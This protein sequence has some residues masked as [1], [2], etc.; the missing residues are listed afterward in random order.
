MG[1]YRALAHLLPSKVSSPNFPTFGL[2]AA[3]FGNAWTWES[4]Q[5]SPSFTW[6]I[7]WAYERV[8]WSG[9][10]LDAPPV[11]VPPFESREGEPRCEHGPFQPIANFVQPAPPPEIHELSLYVGFSP[12]VGRAWWIEGKRVWEACH[13]PDDQG[14]N[15]ACGWTDVGK[16]TSLGDQLWPHPVIAWA[17]PAGEAPLAER[18]D[19][20]LPTAHPKLLMDD[21]WNGGSCVQLDICGPGTGADDAIFRCLWVPVQTIRAQPNK[22]CEA[23]FVWKRVA[24]LGDEDVSVELDVALG[25]QCGQSRVPSIPVDDKGLAN[26]WSK[27]V[28][29]F[30]LLGSSI[31][32]EAASVGLNIGFATSDPSQPYKFSILLGQ[33]AV[34]PTPSP[35][36][37]FPSVIWADWTAYDASG[38]AATATNPAGDASNK[39]LGTLTWGTASILPLPAPLTAVPDPEDPRPIWSP[40]D[41]SL[42]R[43]EFL[44]FNVYALPNTRAPEGPSAAVWVGTSGLGGGHVGS[45]RERL[46]IERSMLPSDVTQRARFYVQGVTSR[47]DVLAWESSTYVDV[48]L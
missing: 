37:S 1:S 7:W 6:E 16:Q 17:D 48:H 45:A 13:C 4:I 26:D 9:P 19:D 33:L 25:V 30:T 22:E 23:T 2:S 28:V 10:P 43:I 11:D 47:G 8:L 34:Y 31:E 38:A 32:P 42:S 39:P 21:A 27:L 44:Y 18:G 5:D 14:C 24:G 3:L 35:L 46:W 29:R 40:D 12:G 20:V 15:Q 36:Q 41:P